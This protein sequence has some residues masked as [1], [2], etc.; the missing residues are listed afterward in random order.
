MA[1]KLT[2]DMIS[3]AYDF[4][5]ETAP[6][7]G[8]RLPHSDEIGFHVVPD[9]NTIADFVLE[10]DNSMHIR[11]SVHNFHT[12]TLIMTVAHEMVHMY[13]CMHKLAKNGNKMALVHNADFKRRAKRICAIHGWDESLF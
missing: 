8:W 1:L 2:P 6:F 12:V 7:K 5:R 3:A 13:Q 9:P 10:Q 11:V 4:L